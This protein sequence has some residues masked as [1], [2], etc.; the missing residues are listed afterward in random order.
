MMIYLKIAVIAV[1]LLLNTAL[2]FASSQQVTA[3]NPHFLY[4]GRID[5]SQAK[6]PYLT[7]PGSQVKAR[8]SGHALTVLL[9]DELGGNFFNIII[10]GQDQYPY[11]IT[12]KQ[13]KHEYVISNVLAAGQHTVEI[14][15]RTEGKEGGTRFL[16]LKLAETGKMLAKP[17]RPSRR[18]EFYGDSITSGMGNEAADN[19]VDRFAS[20]KNHYLSY[21]ALTARAL[22]AEHHS[23][24]YS[25]I[26]IMASWFDFTMPEYFDQLS[27]YGN[28]DSVWDFNQWT[29]DVVVINLL[30][31]DS[32]LV[33]QKKYLSPTPDQHQRINAY[34]TFVND[35]IQRY[36]KA[37]IV[38]AL[39]SMDATKAG[40]LWPS[41]IAKAVDS[42][43][44][45][46]PKTKITSVFFD[47]TGYKRHPRVHQHLRNAAKLTALIQEKMQW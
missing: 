41:Y 22:G 5:F 17:P 28:N 20:E 45:E 43:K 47:F 21:A 19:A 15:K 24:S 32:W 30:Q 25:G 6:A 27:G 31:N 37:L 4:T 12:T 11:V 40:S 16:G 8:F 39:G 14:F 29:P 26:G 46:Q 3:D 38:C 10:D 33:D 44:V 2:C 34:K 42:I 9:D 35:I 36:P 23:I 1:C 13:G 7:W 18:I